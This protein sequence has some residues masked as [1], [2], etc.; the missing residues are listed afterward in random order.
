MD[1]PDA[2]D[3]DD[4]P[5]D[6]PAPRNTIVG[7]PPPERLPASYVTRHPPKVDDPVEVVFSM[8]DGD[9]EVVDLHA[10]TGDLIT[11]KL[12]ADD[13]RLARVHL[14]ECPLCQQNNLT[15]LQIIALKCKE[16]G[17]G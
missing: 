9:A 10:L 17:N 6:G 11:G 13:A 3:R 14:A 7:L 15:D 4:E 8:A 16:N 12:S 5:E 1:L 2:Y